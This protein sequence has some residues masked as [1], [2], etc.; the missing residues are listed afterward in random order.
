MIN[1][2]TEFPINEK[3]SV[4]EI[5]ALA[6]KWIAGSPHTKI[7]E[8]ELS[9]LIGSHEGS[10]KVGNESVATGYAELPDYEIGGF[11][12]SRLEN[13]DIEW[14]T[15]IVSSQTPSQHLVSIQ[16]SCEALRTASYL[17]EPRKPYFVKQVL[18]SIGGGMDGQMPVS[19]KPIV[20]NLGEEHI[21][22]KLILGNAGNSLPI[23]YVSAGFEIAQAVNSEKLARQ[24]SGMAHVIVEP[25]RIFS[26]KL[27]NLTSSRNVYGGTI[28]VY[29]PDSTA[30]KSYFISDENNTPGKLRNSIFRDIR[31]ALAN[32]RQKTYCTWLHLRECISKNRLE[33]L[34]S[35]GSTELDDYVKA[36]D[37]D[38]SAKQEKV[39]EAEREIFRLTAELRKFNSETP[40]R[41]E[42]IIAYG[43][44]QDFYT[45]EIK[46][47]VLEALNGY[48]GSTVVGSRKRHII[49]DLIYHNEAKSEAEEI[50]REIKS[51]FKSYVEMDS[52]IKSALIRLGFDL[53]EDGK[54]HKITFHGDGRYTFAVSKTSSDHR[55][56]KNFASDINKR[57]F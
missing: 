5:L 33:K 34:R 9:D 20:L 35:S 41:D 18:G 3:S 31:L 11:R 39:E 51:I 28:G 6:C 29:W 48:I 17:P 13:G 37:A 38:L 56:G 36:F 1:Y 23:V 4:S 43:L 47:F 44:E 54:H 50:K 49:E 8:E 21:A 55:A 22:A 25:S 2:S 7:K 53:S 52:K 14:V 32:R 46:G 27:K 16:V 40:S 10:I 26:I 24:L 42:G 45:D 30:R 57:L 19:D 15:T 12:Y